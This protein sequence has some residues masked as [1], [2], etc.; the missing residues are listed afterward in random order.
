MTGPELRGDRAVVLAAG[1]DIANQKGDR[2]TGRHAFVNPA[3]Y[4]DL[5]GLAALR[6]VAAAAGRAALE[7]MRE[8]FRRD[9]GARRA[10]IDHAADRRPVRFAEGGDAQQVAKGVHSRAVASSAMRAWWATRSA[11]S[12]TKIPICPTLNSIQ[13]SGS[14]GSNAVNACSASPTSQINKPSSVR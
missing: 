1:I 3:E 4:L 6:G 11:R 10:A 5:V 2:R 12:A 13:A 14:S 8:V 9:G 7:V